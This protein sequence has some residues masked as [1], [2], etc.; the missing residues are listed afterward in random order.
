[1]RRKSKW[2]TA[3]VRPDKN[4]AESSY[5]HMPQVWHAL[6]M[7][8]DRDANRFDFMRLLAAWVVLVSHCYPLGARPEQEPLA[9]TLGLD[10]LGGV[11]V[12]IFFVL[13][14]YLV[15]LSLERSQ[16]LLAFARKRAV[17]IFPGLLVVCLLSVCILG[18]ILTTLPLDSYWQNGQTWTYL[19][20]ISAWS[21]Q[22]ALP[23]VFE[24]TPLPNAVNGSLWSLPYELRCYIFLMLVG[25]LPG[26]LRWKTL[27]VFAALIVLL[28]ARPAVPP[29]TA[30]DKFFGL[31]HFMNKLGLLFALGALFAAWR[32][33][34]QPR[35]WQVLIFAALLTFVPP[36]KARLLFFL[37]TTGVLTLWLALSARY[38]PKIPQ[39]M[40]DWSYG[41]YLYGFV[42]Q[43]ILATL[44][45]NEYNFFLF[46]GLSSLLTL[47]LAGMSWHLVEKPA[48]RWK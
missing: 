17:R 7:T 22:Y 19:K 41:A 29:A 3:E 35:L 15:T 42:V 2:F 11:G 21:I 45:L 34:F 33:F 38:L 24:N 6:T 31:D 40:G 39:R 10:T 1:M 25:V 48:L 43:Q 9:S 16:S 32:E 36:S 18:P 30:F 23:G 14:G 28:L 4:V 26:G 46:M 47:A 44:R 8:L 5:T 12:S 27:F 20:T 13:S 37:L